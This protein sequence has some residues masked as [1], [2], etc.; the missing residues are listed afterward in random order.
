MD[1]LIEDDYDSYDEIFSQHISG[2]K[3]SFEWNQP[4]KYNNNDN[5]R[6]KQSMRVSPAAG[7]GKSAGSGQRFL[8]PT[9]VGVRS[10]RKTSPVVSEPVRAERRP[11]A[12]RY[13]PLDTDELA[14]HKRK[15][16]DVRNWLAGVF[17]GSNRRVGIFYLFLILRNTCCTC[18]C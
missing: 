14:V 18:D 1:D 5:N 16:T 10:V 6:R 8:L 15:V 2:E 3:E 9:D 13:A 12:E 17:A 4:P 11:W 7:V